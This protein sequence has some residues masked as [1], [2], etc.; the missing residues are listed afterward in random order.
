MKLKKWA[1]IAEV[2]AALAVILTLVLLLLEVRSGNQ[3]TRIVTLKDILLEYNQNRSLVIENRDITTSLFESRS[4]NFPA[5]DTP[6][7]FRLRLLLTNDLNAFN[8]AYLAFSAGILEEVEWERLKRA[9]CG[10]V[11]RLPEDYKD[12]IYFRMTD[13]VVAFLESEC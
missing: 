11:E 10:D 4:S 13:D 5:L 6:E 12:A 2:S 9:A 7:G 1:L 8:I 3:L